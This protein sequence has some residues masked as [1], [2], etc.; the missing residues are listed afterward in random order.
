MTETFSPRKT[1]TCSASPLPSTPTNQCPR[2]QMYVPTAPATSTT[3]TATATRRGRSGRRRAEGPP[4]VDGVG[5]GGGV[6]GGSAS[7]G[8]PAAGVGWGRGTGERGPSGRGAGVDLAL[9][10]VAT[11]RA[12]DHRVDPAAAAGVLDDVGDD[13]RDVVGA[14]A[15]QGELDQPV[16]GGLGVGVLERLG[17]RLL[18]DHAG[19][20]V[21]A[22]QVPVAGAGVAHGEVGLDVLTVE[23]AQQQ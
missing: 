9:P 15:A 23:R 3:R 5:V 11:G 10:D 8:P 20:P 21:G 6:A 16:R 13:H 4:P 14:A 22:E 2:A 17:D 19:E 18:A 1:A 7:A 12:V